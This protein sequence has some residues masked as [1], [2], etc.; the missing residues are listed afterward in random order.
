MTDLRVG[1]WNQK[2]TKKDLIE[3]FDQ[4]MRNNKGGIVD[5]PLRYIE[6]HKLEE[7]LGPLRQ[8]CC[9]V[10]SDEELVRGAKLAKGKLTERLSIVRTEEVI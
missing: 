7:S 3:R 8:K 6:D 2:A 10:I 9:G 4:L 1:F 5:F